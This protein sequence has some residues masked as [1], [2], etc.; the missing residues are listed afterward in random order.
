MDTTTNKTEPLTL[1]ICRS[2]INEN[3]HTDDYEKLADYCEFPVS[4]IRKYIKEGAPQTASAKILS[5]RIV[6][7]SIK[8]IKDKSISKIESLD[9]LLFLYELP[10]I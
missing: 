4:T 8:I 7:Y 1:D 10:A 9:K 6:F 5:N 2:F 3:L